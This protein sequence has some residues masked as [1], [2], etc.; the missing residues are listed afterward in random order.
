MVYYPPKEK[1]DIEKI[2]NQDIDVKEGVISKLKKSRR[3]KTYAVFCTLLFAVVISGGYM[4]NKASLTFDKM[5]GEQ[6]SVLKSI[7]RMLPIG[8]KF[9]QILPVEGEDYS[10]ME[11]VKEN[12]LER[13]NV[14]LLGI[15]GVDDPNGGLLTDTMMVASV[16]L[17]TGNVALISIPRDLYVKMPNHETSR[18]INEAYVLGME[19]TK[20]WKGGLDYAKKTVSEVTGL[21]VHYAASVDFRA[22]KEIID[23]MGGVT[24]TLSQPF[25]EL[26]QF[27]EGPISLPAGKQTINGD[28]ALLF[29]RARFSSNDFDRAKRQQQVLMAVKEKAL[30]LG[31][32]SNPLKIV[33]IL[34]TL[35]ND[36]RVDAQLWEIQEMAVLAQR[37]DSTKIK[38]KIFDTTSGGLLYAARDQNGAYILLPDGGDFGKIREEIK[39]LFN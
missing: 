13:L 14:L 19:D 18:K 24:I 21:D 20:S 4:A 10:A 36:V 23:T 25:S 3:K 29:V 8:S 37:L 7:I 15:R 32:L 28:T 11:R 9:F 22:F 38:H 33:S 1:F 12:K 27:E 39:N 5:T 2:V 17:K 35:G 34:D 31:V 6:N 16:E 26:N 30:G